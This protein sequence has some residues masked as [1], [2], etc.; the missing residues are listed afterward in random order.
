MG[1]KALDETFSDISIHQ[2]NKKN[3][4]SNENSSEKFDKRLA[5]SE[6]SENKIVHGY[7]LN[8][9]ANV[10]EDLFEELQI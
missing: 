9:N 2:T 10:N 4:A 1:S 7:T 8:K 3:N 5:L 6:I